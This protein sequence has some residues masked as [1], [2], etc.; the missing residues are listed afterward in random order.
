M[1]VREKIDA[2]LGE[3]WPFEKCIQADAAAA[4]FPYRSANM[5]SGNGK[6]LMPGAVLL[7]RRRRK[8]A[9]PRVDE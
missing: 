4:V 6:H 7:L 9:V 5:I 3:N 8:A 2:W 1:E